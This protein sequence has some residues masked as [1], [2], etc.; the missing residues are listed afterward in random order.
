[1]NLK[2]LRS[3]VI[4]E[5]LEKE[6]TTASGIILKSND[7]ADKAKVVAVGD[8]V[9]DVVV[10]DIVLINWNDAKKVDTDTFQVKQESIIAVFE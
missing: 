5:R 10:G 2:P 1:M 7:D 3:N 6:L 4:I 8:E 9:T